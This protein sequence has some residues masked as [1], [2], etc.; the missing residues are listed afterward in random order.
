MTSSP[1]TESA[2][3]PCPFC[4]AQMRVREHSA[5]HPENDCWLATAGEHGT[6]ELD[7]IDYPAW[8][9]RPPVASPA[10]RGDMNN[11]LAAGAAPRLDGQSLA[12]A[13]GDAPQGHAA[14]CYYCGE[15]CDSYA[16]NP[17][18]WPI[19]LC[20]ADDPGVVKW[21]HTG[22]VSARLIENQPTSAWRDMASA[23]KDGSDILLWAP[24]YNDTPII[25][26]WSEGADAWDSEV[27][28][29]DE[30]PS[31]GGDPEECDGPTHWMPLPLPPGE[32]K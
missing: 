24:D 21:H 25:G 12:P 16:G 28:T 32:E 7:E 31:T 20:H 2:L 18:K 14:P 13:S 15:P 3:L 19:P 27:A 26:R 23:P 9:R 8:N 11:G 17:A 10:G 22:C 1:A 29:M 30:G 4:N 5:F 6:Y